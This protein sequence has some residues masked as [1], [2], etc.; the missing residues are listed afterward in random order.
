MS[1]QRLCSWLHLCELWLINDKI[2]VGSIIPPNGLLVFDGH[3]EGWASLSRSLAERWQPLGN[4][5]AVQALGQQSLEG[6]AQWPPGL[7][8]LLWSMDLRCLCRCWFSLGFLIL[9]LTEVGTHVAEQPGCVARCQWNPTG[10][11]WVPLTVVTS[12]HGGPDAVGS[13]L[14]K[15]LLTLY[16]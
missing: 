13:P 8:Q 2:G 4:H 11:A 5:A 15:G 3:A 1:S 6:R 16:Q 7:S 14:Q 10:M 9:H 12:L